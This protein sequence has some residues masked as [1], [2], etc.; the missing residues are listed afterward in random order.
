MSAVTAS[1]PAREESTAEVPKKKPGPKPHVGPRA[2]CLVFGCE[3][4]STKRHRKYCSSSCKKK[5][6]PW[7]QG[8]GDDIAHQASDAHDMTA[9]YHLEPPTDDGATQRLFIESLPDCAP[10]E[11]FEG[12]DAHDVFRTL[13]PE[14]GAARTEFQFK[15]DDTVGAVKQQLATQLQLDPLSLRVFVDGHEQLD[16]ER[17]VFFRPAAAI[18]VDSGTCA[19]ASAAGSSNTSMEYA[20]LLAAD[21]VLVGGVPKPPSD[22]PAQCTLAMF[23]AMQKQMHAMQQQMQRQQEHFQTIIADQQSELS[24]STSTIAKMHFE[25]DKQNRTTIQR[26]Y[27]RFI[28]RRRDWKRSSSVEIQSAVRRFV[29][30]RRYHHVRSSAA[31]LIQTTYRTHVVTTDL[32]S[33]VR[34]LPAGEKRVMFLIPPRLLQA[35]KARSMQRVAR[36]RAARKAVHRLHA[37]A[38]PLQALVRKLVGRVRHIKLRAAAVR[39]QARARMHRTRWPERGREL[40]KLTRVHVQQSAENQRLQHKLESEKAANIRLRQKNSELDTRVCNDRYM[41]AVPW[42]GALTY[43]CVCADYVRASMPHHARGY[44][45]PGHLC[46]R[47]P[48]VREGSDDKV[49]CHARLVAADAGTGHLS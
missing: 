6:G 11:L 1:V 40:F 34:G 32:S 8:S 15:P 39:L 26:A 23:Q 43:R 17:C 4:E 28:I 45:G 42:T 41:H 33:K 12:V 46:C 24:R 22:E 25:T 48:R 30:R 16:N 38:I 5:L 10:A 18:P 29:A 49:G 9:L 36:G 27:R 47:R 3:S 14:C 20:E 7:K 31:I 37:S 2:T 19:A 13:L 35:S 44:P 21:F